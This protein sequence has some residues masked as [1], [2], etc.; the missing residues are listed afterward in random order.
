MSSQ[1]LVPAAVR[2]ASRSFT[3]VVLM[4]SIP[5]RWWADG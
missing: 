5:S 4:L 3:A 1:T 2:A